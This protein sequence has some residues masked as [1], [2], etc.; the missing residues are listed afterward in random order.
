MGFGLK[1]STWYIDRMVNVL[2]TAVMTMPGYV[3]Y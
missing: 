3:I 1:Y 2:Y